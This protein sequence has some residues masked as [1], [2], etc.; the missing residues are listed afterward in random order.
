MQFKVKSYHP[1]GSVGRKY[2]AL[3]QK[4][5]QTTDSRTKVDNSN[6]LYYNLKTAHFRQK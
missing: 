6:R 3:I 5:S 2:I 4:D 1:M